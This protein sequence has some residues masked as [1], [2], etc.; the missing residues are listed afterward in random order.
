MVSPAKSALAIAIFNG[1]GQ[2]GCFLSPYVINYI[3]KIFN[4]D[5]VI[6][7]I[8]SGIFML[9]VTLLHFIINPIHKEDIS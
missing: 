3:S 2:L 6:T 7:F 8:V 4:S 9:V 1:C 5:I